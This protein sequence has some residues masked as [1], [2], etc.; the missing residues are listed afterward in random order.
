MSEFISSFDNQLWG[1]ISNLSCDSPVLTNEEEG[2][3]NMKIYPDLSN[4][5]ITRYNKV[6][7]VKKFKSRF[8]TQKML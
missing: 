4:D 6:L 5:C 7:H 2:K 1:R 8:D 3:E